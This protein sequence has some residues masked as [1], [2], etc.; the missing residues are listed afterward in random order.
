MSE[1]QI[2]QHELFGS[3]RTIEQDGKIHFCGKDVATSLGYA[4]PT[5]AVT[6][7]CKGVSKMGIPTKG[8]KQ[9]TIFIA[10]GDIYR[11]VV[12]SQ[13]P[14]AE[15][16]ESWIFDEVIPQIRQTGGYIPMKTAQ[17]SPMSDAEIMASALLIAQKTIQQRDALLTT[18]NNQIAVLQPKAD[19]V[20]MVL[21]CKDMMNV[22]QIAQDYGMSATAFNKLLE[23][24][25]VQY[26]RGDE[27]ILYAAYKGLGWVGSTSHAYTHTDQTQ[28]IAVHTKWTQKGR[29]GLYELLKEKGYVPVMESEHEAYVNGTN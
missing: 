29:L 14:E 9:L 22:T 19:Y 17:A 28:G 12:G 10:E 27:W 7:H 13:L 16:F 23:T 4:N 1:L 20:D 18:A 21:N 25:K 11:L 6:T 3:V 26:K 5:K 8:G 15:K 2:F 24:L